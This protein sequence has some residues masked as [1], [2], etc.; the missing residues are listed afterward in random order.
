MHTPFMP[1]LSASSNFHIEMHINH[2]K[3]LLRRNCLHN[4]SNI[5]IQWKSFEV[6]IARLEYS[7]AS[8]QTHNKL[9]G[10]KM[11]HPVYVPCSEL[12]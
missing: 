7:T 5:V 4:R 11:L 12:S 9:V 10:R 3:P 6:W 8:D 2:M 1:D